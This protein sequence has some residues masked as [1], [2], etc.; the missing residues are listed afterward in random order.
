MKKEWTYMSSDQKTPIHA[1]SWIPEQKIKAV[2]QIAHGMVEFINRYDHFASFL[3]DQGFLVVGHDH[4]GH[5]LSVTREEDLGFFHQDGGNPYVIADIHQLRLNTQAAYPDVPYFV[6]GHSMG[7]FLMRQYI[8]MHG[9][10]LQGAI[11]MG[12]GS[13]N[14]AVVKFGQ[15]L[16]HIMALFKGWHYRSEFVNQMA[17]GAYN[18]SFAPVRTSRDWL[19][20]DEAMVDAYIN[21]PL[22][23]F[24]FTLNGYETLFATIAYIQKKRHIDQIPK[25]LPILLISGEDDPVGDQGR[26]V[27]KAMEGFQQAG[28]KEVTLKLYPHDR[29]EILNETDCFLV[30]HDLL[31]WLDEHLERT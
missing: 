11:I 29:H 1:I 6:M 2:L 5:G 16:T 4:L 26:G 12:T 14:Q 18:K 21:E 25:D 27:K 15:S 13:Q 22:C 24:T 8:M 10:G 9:E 30:E 31:N 3:A 20:K 23:M 28:I 17:F 7:S 19:S